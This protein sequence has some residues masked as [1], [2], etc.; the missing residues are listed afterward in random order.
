MTANNKDFKKQIQRVKDLILHYQTVQRGAVS[1]G[2]VILLSSLVKKCEDAAVRNDTQVI[3]IY[4]N[5]LKFS[6]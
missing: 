4:Y 5:E 3:G 1:R 2:K 6:Y